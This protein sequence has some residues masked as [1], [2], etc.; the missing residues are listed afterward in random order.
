MTATSGKK[1]AFLA[2]HVRIR[3]L[4]DAVDQWALCALVPALCALVPS[5][6]ITALPAMSTTKTYAPE[7]EVYDQRP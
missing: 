7:R 3:R 5:T 4:Y 6:T 1:L 2:R